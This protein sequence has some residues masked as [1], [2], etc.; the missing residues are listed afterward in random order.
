MLGGGGIT[1]IAWELGLL[2]GLAAAGVDLTDADLVVGTSA[3]SVVGAQIRSG[4]P[5]PALYDAQLADPDGEIAAKM[6]LPLLLRYAGAM[7]A[8]RNPQR[9]RRRIGSLALR[10]DAV[11]ESERL[12]VISE[13]LAS[14]NWPD[15]PLLITA[16]DAASG[17]FEVFSVT[18][19]VSLVDAVA[20]SCAVPG[21]WPPITIG[22]RRFIDGGMRSG[23]NVDLAAECDRIVVLAPLPRGVGPLTSAASQVADLDPYTRVTLVS[24]DAAAR[25]AIGR[26]VLD[27]ARRAGAARAGM[28]QARNVLDVVA[29]VWSG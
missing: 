20:A 16:V 6:G 28:A 24:P 4:E 12:A 13:R 11:A 21:V 1:G 2:A 23:T 14:L 22:A 10:A 15:R 25:T 5:L 3:G 17:A 29:A 9:F 7:L 18:S 26:K 27:P 8:A 19:G